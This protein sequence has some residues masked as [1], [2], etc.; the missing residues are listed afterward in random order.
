MDATIYSRFE[1]PRLL[2]EIPEKIQPKTLYIA[3][4]PPPPDALIISIVGTR[5]PTSYGKEVAHEIAG[6]LARARIIIASGLALG[7]DSIAHTAA[8]EAGTP[9]IAI[10]GSGINENLLYPKENVPLARRIIESGGSIISEYDAS[11]KPELW[12]FPQRN[13]IIAG[14]AQATIVIEAGEK[15][16]ALITARFANDFNRDVFALPGSIFHSQSHGTNT[17]IKDGATPITSVDSIL[18]ALGLETTTRNEK[19]EAATEEE[20][21]ILKVLDEESS[22]DEIIKKTGLSAQ[23]VLSTTLDLEIRGMIKNTGGGIYR[24]I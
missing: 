18:A 24:K 23:K 12:T 19:L 20:R 4:A 9:T 21:L 2:R 13:R 6:A 16:G 17:L 1:W 7:I 22:L 11:Q 3:G 8:L 15:S 10:L 5:R 14:I